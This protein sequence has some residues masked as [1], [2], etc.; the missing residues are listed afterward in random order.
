MVEFTCSLLELDIVGEMLRADVGQFPFD[1]PLHG[2]TIEERRRLAELAQRNLTERGL[3]D[4]NDFDPEFAGLVLLFARG[5]LSIAMLGTTG[6]RRYLARASTDGQSGVL[7]TL[8]D[9]RVTLRPV[10][11]TGMVR[12]LVSLL[13][14]MKPGVGT[15]VSIPVGETEQPRH[16]QGDDD[17]RAIEAILARPRL[18]AGY[19]G[20]TARDRDDRESEPLTLNWLDTDAGRYMIVSDGNERVTYAPADQSHIDQALSFHLRTV[21]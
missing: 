3:F 20:V 13:P 7:A 10:P 12:S 8:E 14:P 19:F 18:G 11:P 16:G 9:Q 1:I 21:E 6:D 17:D 2:G 15:A 4:G 5:E